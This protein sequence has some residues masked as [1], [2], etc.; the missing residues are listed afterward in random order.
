MTE[1]DIIK[2]T[3][4]TLGEDRERN[5]TIKIIDLRIKILYNMTIDSDSQRKM[6]DLNSQVKG[7]QNLKKELYGGKK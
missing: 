3:S 2:E 6:N 7:L 1:R 5:R 4:I